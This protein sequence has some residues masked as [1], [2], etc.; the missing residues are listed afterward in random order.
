MSEIPTIQIP[1]KWKDFL[2]RSQSYD[3]RLIPNLAVEASPL[4]KLLTTSE[5]P[6]SV[7]VAVGPEGDFTPDEVEAA[8]KLEFK[9]THLGDLVMRSETA[10]LF[11]L[12]ALRLYYSHKE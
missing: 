4:K 2:V 3:L 11:V 8:L 10:A 1:M 7:V 9:S 12:G 6:A 5:I